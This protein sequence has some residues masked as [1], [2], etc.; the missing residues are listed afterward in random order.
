[1]SHRR[2]TNDGLAARQPDE[3]IGEEREIAAR[4][5]RPVAHEAKDA[6]RNEAIT[7]SVWWMTVA[8]SIAV[9]LVPVAQRFW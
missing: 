6:E 3:A 8:V 7:E 2:E 4:G 9:V 5:A 1:V